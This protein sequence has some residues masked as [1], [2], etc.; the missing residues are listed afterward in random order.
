MGD[1]PGN[2]FGSPHEAPGVAGPVAGVARPP[3][4]LAGVAGGVPSA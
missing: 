3:L 4:P 1:A 2:D